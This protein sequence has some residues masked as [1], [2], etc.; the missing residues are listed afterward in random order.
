MELLDKVTAL[1]ASQSSLTF[2]DDAVIRSRLASF[3]SSVLQQMESMVAGG[4]G[5]LTAAVLSHLV[6][7]MT[8][9]EFAEYASEM[10]PLIESTCSAAESPNAHRRSL[11]EIVRDIATVVRRV[12]FHVPADI[13]KTIGVDKLSAMICTVFTCPNGSNG[14]RLT[15]EYWWSDSRIDH[16]LDEILP[17]LTIINEYDAER[18]RE[19]ETA[20][21]FRRTYIHLVLSDSRY[22]ESVYT[23]PDE[24]IER[25]ANMKLNDFA[26]YRK[27]NSLF[28]TDRCV[29]YVNS[30]M[31]FIP[32]IPEMEMLWCGSVFTTAGLYFEAPT[33]GD[34]STEPEGIRNQYLGMLRILTSAFK[35]SHEDNPDLYFDDEVEDAVWRFN[36]LLV[37]ELIKRNPDRAIDIAGYVSERN[38]M[39]LGALTELVN[40]S[41]PALSNGSL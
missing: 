15:P 5:G 37:V 8:P 23:Y 10:G 41:A 4:S 26:E 1:L 40:S 24:V 38:N 11:T 35:N 28:Y 22:P 25:L 14:P 34:Y 9:D 17:H 20:M 2:N 27:V 13:R 33:S 31:H 7:T 18:I 16:T 29:G 19:S 30:A 36:D 32:R 39:N 12:L 6:G 21:I 3:N